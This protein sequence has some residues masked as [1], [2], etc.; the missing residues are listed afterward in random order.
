MVW[1][2]STTRSMDLESPFRRTPS[3]NLKF[4]RAVT[5]QSM[6]GLPALSS[7]LF[8]NKAVTNLK[9][10]FSPYFGVGEFLLQMPLPANP[11][12]ATLTHRPGLHWAGRCKEAAPSSSLPLILPRKILLGF[13]RSV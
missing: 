1:M 12:R 4:S 9:E 7:M 6:E 10:T 2:L 5:A 3:R 11:T 8:Q 13:Q